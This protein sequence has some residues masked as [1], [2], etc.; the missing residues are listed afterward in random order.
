M[1]VKSKLKNQGP[2][3]RSKLGHCQYFSLKV[4]Q[5]SELFSIF[6]CDIIPVLTVTNCI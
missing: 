3:H 6:K 5:V 4:Q 1:Y 2:S